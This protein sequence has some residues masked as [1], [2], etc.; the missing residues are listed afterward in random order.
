MIFLSLSPAQQTA[1]RGSV[2]SIINIKHEELMPVTCP[3]RTVEVLQSILI[4]WD[5]EMRGMSALLIFKRIKCNRSY[6]FHGDTDLSSIRW[7]ASTCFSSTHHILT[8]WLRSPL[9]SLF[10]ALALG[11]I[12]CLELRV[13]GSL[14]EKTEQNF[15]FLQKV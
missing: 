7:S 4:G 13:E 12:P 15:I 9:C 8:C 2:C 14:Y 6:G 3:W 11:S 1:V 10:W 5:T